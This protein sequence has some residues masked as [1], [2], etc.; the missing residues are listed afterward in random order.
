MI[1][2]LNIALSDEVNAKKQL[3]KKSLRVHSAT[4]EREKVA[5]VNKAEVRLCLSRTLTELMRQV[6]LC[7]HGTFH[8]EFFVPN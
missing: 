8:S 2:Q 6:V 7:T 5:R 4:S 3:T 1:I